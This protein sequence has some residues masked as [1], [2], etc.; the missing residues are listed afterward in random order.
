M[1]LNFDRISFFFLMGVM[2]A[3][4]LAGIVYALMN[5]FGK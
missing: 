5:M 2:G 4:A 1:K 3:A